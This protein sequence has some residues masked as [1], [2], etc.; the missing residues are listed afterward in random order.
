M[1]I[2]LHAGYQQRGLALS[3]FAILLAGG[4]ARRFGLWP[5]KGQIAIGSAADLVL[6]DLGQQFV[7]Q[8]E[9]LHYQHQLSPY[10]GMPHTGAIIRTILRGTTIVEQGRLIAPGRGQ[11]LAHPA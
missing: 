1:G 5:R 4:A 9:D 3:H 8:R 2:M 10:I 11:F 6:V 7:L